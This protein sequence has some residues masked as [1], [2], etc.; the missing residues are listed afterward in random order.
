MNANQ[1]KS[2]ESETGFALVAVLAF[3]LLAAA[4][5]TPFLAGAKIQALV[6]RNTGQF[7]REKILLR[8][9]IEIA[10]TR[11]FELYQKRDY[12]AASAVFCPTGGPSR[13]DVLFHFQDHS[14]LI[15]LNAASAEVLAIGFESLNMNR[16]EAAMLAGEVIR[17]RSVN[18]GQRSSGGPASPRGGYKHALFERSAELQDLLGQA[19][20]AQV[21]I[22]HAFTVHS[23]TGTID[24]AAAQGALLAR[25]SAIKVSER[26]FI[27]SNVRRGAAV[28]VEVGLDS[29][30]GHS[31]LG[32]AV[33]APGEMPGIARIVEPMSFTRAAGK[34]A[35]GA[36]GQVLKCA[37][38]FD[39]VLLEAI[40]RVTS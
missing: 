19:K 5:T 28:T 31:V 15:D 18:D 2:A 8:G 39:P 13:P 25:L 9:L 29:G 26:F 37:D 20:I 23:G 30:N 35:P 32:R 14:G 38:F 7:T 21:E 22:D 12:D 1:D 4:F 6:T 24:E 16:Q 27:V 11:F 40:A 34:S 3:L 10:A 36:A 33:F 17:F